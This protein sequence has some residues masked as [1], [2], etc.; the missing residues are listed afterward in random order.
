M[1]CH[2][3]GPDPFLLSGGRELAGLLRATVTP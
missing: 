3:D 2:L 1:T